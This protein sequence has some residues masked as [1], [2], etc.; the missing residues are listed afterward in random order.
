MPTRRAFVESLSV[1]ADSFSVFELACEFFTFSVLASS[2]QEGEGILGRI[3]QGRRARDETVGQSRQM[4]LALGLE[5]AKLPALW[6][7]VPIP[8]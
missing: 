6:T 7:N 3:A 4:L 2:C 5:A 8:R 1:F